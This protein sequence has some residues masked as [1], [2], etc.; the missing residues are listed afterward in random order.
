MERLTTDGA[1]LCS[2]CA[3]IGSCRITCDE[4]ERYEKLAKYENAEEQELIAK[5][6]CRIGQEIYYLTNTGSCKAKSGILKRTV[7][8][9]TVYNI[10]IG[11]N[12]WLSLS[13]GT[14][15]SFNK[16][17]IGKKLFFNREEA[18]AALLK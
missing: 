15:I 5:L 7:K 12:G 13:C 2:D 17:D 1:T 8:C 10:S 4:Q 3:G 9:R 6:P 11:K 14:T 16:T 18:E